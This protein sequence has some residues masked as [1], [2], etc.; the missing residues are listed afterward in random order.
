MYQLTDK[1]KDFLLTTPKARMKVAMRMGVTEQAIL[2]SIKR[3]GNGSSI[4]NNYDGFNQL[5]DE[6][7]L[8][9]KELRIISNN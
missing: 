6:S 5:I 8:A 3:K 2:K 9:A 7:G 1:A 4:A